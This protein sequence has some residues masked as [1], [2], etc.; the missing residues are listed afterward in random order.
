MRF[1]LPRLSSGP[2]LLLAFLALGLPAL[3]PKPVAAQQV[4]LSIAAVVNDDAITE[5]DVERR[6]DYIMAVSNIPD[7]QENRRR[8]YPQILD[9]LILEKLKMQ[10]AGR[11][12]LTVSRSDLQSGIRNLEEQNGMPPGGLKASVEAKGADWKTVEEQF[13]AD[14]AWIK[15]V[16]SSLRRKVD[17]ADQEVDVILDQLRENRTKRQYRLGEIVLPVDDPGREKTIAAAAERLVDQIRNGASFGALARQFS[18]SPTAAKGGDM[19]WI[20]LSDLPS[21]VAMVVS[22]MQPK[23]VSTPIR[24]LSGFQIVVLAGIKEPDPA[25]LGSTELSLSQLF[26]PL[27]GDEALSR[28]QVSTIV[29]RAKEAQSCEAFNALAEEYKLAGSGAMG[30][31]DLNDL[32]SHIRQAVGPLDLFVASQPVAVSGGQSILMVCDRKDI[33]GEADAGLPS[34]DQVRQ[35]L[36]ID[37]LEI[38]ANRELRDLRRAAF[39]DIRHDR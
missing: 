28:D 31:I 34:R 26:L 7:R 33:P 36:E 10:E 8:L 13:R 3:S 25:A 30:E 37:R 22:Q 20:T 11:L 27:E 21:E 15:V 29:E 5:H 39:I 38:L 23:Q 32:P 35:K 19:G 12:N 16:R 1:F 14:L 4:N 18:Q 2:A 17:I 6:M 9:T 24:T